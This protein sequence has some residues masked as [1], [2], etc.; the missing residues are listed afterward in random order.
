M[1]LVRGSL[2]AVASWRLEGPPP[3]RGPA[4]KATQGGGQGL[5]VSPGWAGG[6]RQRGREAMVERPEM[7][8]E[9][10]ICCSRTKRAN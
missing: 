2:G 7:P 10:P 1:D 8:L 4:T 6:A 9:P 3:C 5:K